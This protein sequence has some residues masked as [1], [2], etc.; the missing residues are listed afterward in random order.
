MVLDLTLIGLAIT[1][2]PVP[3]LAFILVLAGDRGLLK[4][5]AFILAWLACLVLV[6]VVV[7]TITGGK[8]LKPHTSPSVAAVA[9]KLAIGVGLVVYG[10]RRRRRLR[11]PRPARSSPAW[12]ARLDRASVWTAAGMA[13]LLQPWGL[14]AAGAAT[15][16]EAHLSGLADYLV[17][18][19][20]CL[21]A[22]ASLLVMELW[23]VFAPERSSRAFTALRT[24]IEGHQEQAIVLLSLLVGLWLVGKSISELAS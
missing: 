1:L 23:T 3:V 21:L 8:P 14:V 9:V 5:L 17:L 19:G 11:R 6:I 13:V 22:T 7:T 2:E 18:C 4:G 16:T 20:F 12:M 15:V 24:W 10:E